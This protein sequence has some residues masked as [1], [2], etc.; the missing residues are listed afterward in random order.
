MLLAKDTCTPYNSVQDASCASPFIFEI[1]ALYLIYGITD[2]GT[3]CGK[4]RAA[5][6]GDRAKIA[7][8]P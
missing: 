7:P 1:K 5:F 8:L 2:Q 4:P 6:S 3:V